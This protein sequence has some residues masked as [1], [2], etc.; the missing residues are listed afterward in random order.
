MKKNHLFL[1]GK[2]CGGLTV[3]ACVLLAC[4]CTDSIDPETFTPG[5]TNTTLSAPEVTARSNADGSKTIVE[6]PVVM[7]AGGVKLSL[8]NVD[9]AAN[10]VP[11]V[12]DTVIDG[13]TAELPRTE[14]TYYKL[15]IQAL[16]SEKY[17]NTESEVKE[18]SFSSWVPKINDNPL[19]PGTDIT[20]WFNEHADLVAAQTEE[21]SVELAGNGEYTMSGQVDLGQVPFVLYSKD[22]EHKAVIKMDSLAGFITETGIKLKYVE[23]DCAGMLNP[24][25]SIILFPKEPLKEKYPAAKNPSWNIDGTTPVV[26]Q[27]VRVKNLTT[28]LI[29]TSNV[30]WTVNTILVDNCVIGV[31]QVAMAAAKGNTIDMSYGFVYNLKLRNS[32]FYSTTELASNAAFFVIMSQRPHQYLDGTFP[33][34]QFEYLNNTFVNCTKGGKSG[35]SKY[36]FSYGRLKGQSC[37]TTIVKNNIFVDCSSNRVVRGGIMQGQNGGMITEF[38]NNCYFY[39]GAEPDASTDWDKGDHVHGDPA[40][41]QTDEGW[42]KVNGAEVKAA[43][44]GDPR[45]LE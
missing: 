32:T 4:G 16:G 29:W 15:T 38:A 24:S 42:Y 2:T 6:W 7:G 37:C 36:M 13:S 9:D 34:C 19:E 35:D 26:L 18:Y 27:S 21:Y 40:L 14:D 8:Y 12:V 10:P 28:H 3:M 25:S 44:C 23:F 11:V 22:K 43:G 5:V 41:V 31:D 17:N 30:C 20:K 39:G 33:T 1:R 45:G